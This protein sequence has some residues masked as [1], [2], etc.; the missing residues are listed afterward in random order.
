MQVTPAGLYYAPADVYID[1]WRAVPKA[2]ITHAHGDHA[3]PGSAQYLCAEDSV[4]LVKARVYSDQVAG[5]KY[6]ETIKI[7][8][9]KVSFHPAG[10]ILGSAQIRLEHAGHVS[11]VSGDYKLQSDPTCEPF[12]PVRCN[13]F[14]S[15]CTFGL[16]IYHWQEPERV[17]AEINDWW[18]TNAAQG[19]TSVLFA[20]A[21]GKSQRLLSGI[22]PSIGPIGIHGL[23]NRFMP[24]YS[25]R[26]KFPPYVYANA[27]TAPLLKNRGLV[28][29][30]SS[31]QNTSWLDRFRPHSLASASGWMAVRGTRRRA[32]YDRGFVL[33]D[34]SD[35]KDL[36]TAV[37]DTGAEEVWATHGFISSFAKA[38]SE[39]GLQ[40]RE[41]STHF[42]GEGGIDET[43]SSDEQLAE[44]VT[45]SEDSVL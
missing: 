9:A 23:M 36:L 30:P 13:L 18:S 21:L 32:G 44:G 12:T 14:V 35:W 10:H 24:Y 11:V 26:V 6:E 3:R 4:G 20:Y 7:G 5:I 41:L 2:L 34:H 33:S 45:Q 29:C 43:G 8:D 17:F 39:R 25:K 40:V 1:P 38:L 28:I 22:D 27:E 16:P 42:E 37:R 15:E 31:V 19:K